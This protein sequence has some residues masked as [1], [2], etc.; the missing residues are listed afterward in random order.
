ML[1]ENKINPIA[2]PLQATPVQNPALDIMRRKAPE[3]QGKVFNPNR[4]IS[5]LGMLK[6]TI[7]RDEIHTASQTL[8]KY[9]QGKANLEQ[10]I[11]ENEQWY[12]LRH[13]ECLRDKEKDIE[14]T[15]AWL[16]NTLVNKHADGMDNFP[17]PN[18]LPREE[19]DKAEAEMLTSIV[20]VVLDQ[21]NFE[22]TYSEVL[23]QKIHSGTGIYGVF[24]D[25]TKLNGLGDIA[26]TAIDIINLFWEPGIKD[27]QKSKNIFHVELVDNETLAG[28]YPQLRGKLGTKTIDIA[29]YVHD[30][31]V[32]TTNKSAVVDWY[33]KK[34]VGGK[35]VLH[36]C[37]YVNDEVLF[38][39]ENE[40][41]PVTD[42]IGNVIRPPMAQCGWY[43]HGM[44][45]FVFDV[46]FSVKGT[47]AG[48]GYIDI[49]KSPQ[50][51]I[52][53]GN[54][55]IMEN[56]LVN[57]KPRYFI[58]ADGT[59]NEEEFADTTKP[60]VHIQGAGL[61]EDSIREIKGSALSGIYVNVITQKI[62]ELKETS[63]NRDISQGGTTSGVTAASAIA[64]MQE[65]GSKLSRDHNKASFRA[66]KSLCLMIIELIRQFYDIPRCFRIMGENGAQRFVQYG[67]QNIKPMS[68]G[69]EHGLE[70]GDRIPLFDIE[71]TAQKA[72]P[73]SKMAQ[74]ELALSFYGQGFFNPQLA[75]QALACLEM[76]DFDRKQF[77]IQ[78]VA[79][80]GTMYQKLMQM[81]QQMLMLAQI[82]DKHEGSNIAAQIMAGVDGTPVIMGGASNTKAEKKE[83]LVGNENVEASNTKKAR[84]RVAESTDPT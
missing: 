29:E 35:T 12:K 62:D 77:V 49:D 42:Q 81:Q 27:I 67:N 13:W 7:G 22:Q 9:K 84:Q 3:T 34:N 17:S 4:S 44:Y 47:P 48:F 26:I 24:W 31:T 14:P 75:D 38:A 43:A 15:S 36:Y 78:K 70:L 46:L 28:A 68:Q 54:Q 65:A 16:F 55:A 61:G 11:I 1:D 41:E 40:T 50:T 6:K 64:A 10:R 76:M 59:V 60:F 74:N 52:D 19:G 83:T 72:S 5:A 82:V 58:R 37:K 80:N 32:D 21:N 23:E 66:F 18:I 8:Q 73:Y 71:V 51:F 69:T 33:Y 56:M 25:G 39:T 57:S 30:D 20:P 53:R 2:P 79:Q 45:P 63:G